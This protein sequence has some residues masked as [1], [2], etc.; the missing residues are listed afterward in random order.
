M[1]PTDPNHWLYRLGPLE[2]LRAA[3]G[4]LVQAEAAFTRSRDRRKALTLARRAAGMALNAALVVQLREHW[5][6]SYVEHL[7]AVSTDP[8]VPQRVR[9]ASARLAGGNLEGPT[10][11]PLGSLGRGALSP[12]EADVLSD[13]VTL[14]DWCVEQVRSAST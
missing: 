7:E 2:W 5:G 1:P 12:A 6:R 14:Y 3:R 4:E 8:A 9:E 10:L 13:A 11:V